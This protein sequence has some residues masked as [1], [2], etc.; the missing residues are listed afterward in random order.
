MASIMFTEQ[1]IEANR[2]A[3][4]R[5]YNRT[6]D[7]EQ[8]DQLDPNGVHLVIWSMEHEHAGGVKVAPHVRAYIMVKLRN[9]QAPVKIMLDMDMKMFNELQKV[10]V[11]EVLDRG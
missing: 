9:M 5:H 8:I 2:L 6:L 7:S 1:L 3:V 10:N 11:E 4:K